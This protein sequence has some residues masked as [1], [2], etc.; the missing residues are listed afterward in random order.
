MAF[1]FSLFMTL[2]KYHLIQKVFSDLLILLP[3]SLPVLASLYV[4]LSEMILFIYLFVLSLT[5]VFSLKFKS[6]ETEQSSWDYFVFI[7]I[8]VLY[9]IVY[10]RNYFLV[11]T[12]NYNYFKINVLSKSC[13]SWI[14]FVGNWVPI[15][16]I[17]SGL[18]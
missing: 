5:H 1:S 6:G 15:T 14:L 10:I 9:S 8:I 4:L 17:E 16:R 7:C 11:S 2:L 12:W 3:P 13:E 18:Q